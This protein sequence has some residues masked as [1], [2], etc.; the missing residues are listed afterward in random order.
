M[1]TN[2]DQPAA[3]HD[4]DLL[5]KLQLINNTMNRRRVFGVAYCFILLFLFLNLLASAQYAQQKKAGRDVEDDDDV[6]QQVLKEEQA[7]Y[8]DDYDRHQFEDDQNFDAEA[9]QTEYIRKEEE[10]ERLEQERLAARER[11]E[12]ER[13]RQERE[14]AFELEVSQMEEAKAKA[15]RKQKKKDAQICRRV[16]N[17]SKHGD[18]YRVLGL[19]NFEIELGERKIGLWKLALTIPAIK[20]F[21]IP[22]KKIRKAYRKLSLAVHPDR[23]RDGRAHEAFLALEESASILSDEKQRAAVD[24]EIR[25]KRQRMKQ[26]ALQRAHGAMNASVKLTSRTIGIVRSV[27]GPFA[28]PV[29]IIGALIV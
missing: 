18:H 22:A 15:A 25:R 5:L 17:A 26:E 8:G 4:D 11:Q 3:D 12:A 19:W 10:A 16:L 23:N 28:V 27:L 7:H 13:I 29:S 2:D 21:R 9:Y 1:T 14:A 20:L 24:K 6:V